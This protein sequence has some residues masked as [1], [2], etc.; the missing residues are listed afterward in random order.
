MGSETKKFDES[1]LLP[2]FLTATVIYINEHAHTTPRY[3]ITACSLDAWLLDTHTKV[4]KIRSARGFFFLR[5]PN[6][7]ERAIAAMSVKILCVLLYRRRGV[8]VQSVKVK[9]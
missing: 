4:P 9:C 1:Y 5:G 2:C 7:S 3:I 8:V 6:E